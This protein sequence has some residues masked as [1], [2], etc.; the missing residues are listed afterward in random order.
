MARA[1]TLGHEA[2]ELSF[3][4][5]AAKGVSASVSSTGDAFAI[6]VS[7]DSREG[8]AEVLSRAQR[9]VAR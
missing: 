2:P 8:A 3:C 1:A 7:A 6:N 5:L 9:L 4:P